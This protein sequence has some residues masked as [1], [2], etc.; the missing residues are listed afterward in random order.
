M[1][2]EVKNVFSKISGPTER[3]DIESFSYLLHTCSCKNSEKI[4]Y[5]CNNN[6]LTM[7][8]LPHTRDQMAGQNLKY[9]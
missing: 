2:Y 6:L 3:M 9:F 7:K 8:F 1:A 5:L 4:A